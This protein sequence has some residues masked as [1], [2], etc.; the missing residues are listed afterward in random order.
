MSAEDMIRR[1]PKEE[2]PKEPFWQRISLKNVASAA[3]ALEVGLV[4][5]A[6]I[7]WRF[8]LFSMLYTTIRIRMSTIDELTEASPSPGILLLPAQSPARTVL[9]SR[10]AKFGK[11]F[12]LQRF[13][14]L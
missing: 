3:V 6:Y 14:L 7:T 1:L 12:N 2:K 5:V 8:V 9:P 11:Q 13:Q 10:A 4:L